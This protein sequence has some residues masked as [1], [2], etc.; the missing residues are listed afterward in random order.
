MPTDFIAY[1]ERSCM[2]LQAKLTVRYATV[3]SFRELASRT[4]FRTIFH[5]LWFWTKLPSPTII[6]TCINL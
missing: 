2:K 4:S 5:G 6:S 3:F 1:F